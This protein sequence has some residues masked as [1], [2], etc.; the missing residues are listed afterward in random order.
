MGQVPSLVCGNPWVIQRPPLVLA[1]PQTEVG[2]PEPMVPILLLRKNTYH[3]K[4]VTLHPTHL[5]L[6]YSSQAWVIRPLDGIQSSP[7][8]MLVLPFS[9]SSMLAHISPSGPLSRT[10]HLLLRLPSS[11]WW[12]DILPMYLSTHSSVSSPSTKVSRS[13]LLQLGIPLDLLGGTLTLWVLSILPRGLPTNQLTSDFSVI[14]VRD[15]AQPS[16]PH[17][18]LDE[19]FIN[20]LTPSL[21]SDSIRR[22]SYPNLVNLGPCKCS[23]TSAI[24]LLKSQVGLPF[25][26]SKFLSPGQVCSTSPHL[27]H[28]L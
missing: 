24:D 10:F 28:T 20:L 6:A 8:L 14:Q 27:V 13:Y 9:E 5:W 12:M 26:T 22:P 1:R 2:G 21:H 11:G 15:L 7:S 25:L 23:R 3:G 4:Q 19:L 17:L 16:H 18:N